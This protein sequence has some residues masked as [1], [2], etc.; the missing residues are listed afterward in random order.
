MVY[1]DS[2]DSTDYTGIESFVSNEIE[3]NNNNWFPVNNAVC[4]KEYLHR[5]GHLQ[6]SQEP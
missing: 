5:E 6:T 3:I 1:L 4:L 2:K